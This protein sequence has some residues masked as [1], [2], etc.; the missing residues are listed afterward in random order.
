MAQ[1]QL[2]RRI[3]RRL[4]RSR[5]HPGP[6][7]VRDTKNPESGVLTFAP[8]AWGAFTAFFKR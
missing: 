8:G 1:V 5:Q 3:R 6:I 2:Q 4:H 7:L